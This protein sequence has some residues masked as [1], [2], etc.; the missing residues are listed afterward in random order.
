LPFV[1]PENRFLHRGPQVTR[2]NARRH[3]GGDRTLG[4]LQQRPALEFQRERRD[5]LVLA[6]DLA[7]RPGTPC[8][9]LLCHADETLAL[10]FRQVRIRHGLD[11]RRVGIASHRGI[12]DSAAAL[13]ARAMAS[14]TPG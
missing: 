8:D 2:I 13:H 6:A 12:L 7:Y 3:D 14:V 10:A 11:S 5:D 1:P 9:L 4:T